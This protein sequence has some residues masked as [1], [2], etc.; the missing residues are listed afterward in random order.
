MSIP[1][2][3]MLPPTERYVGAFPSAEAVAFINGMKQ[4]M[5]FFDDGE[6]LVYNAPPRYVE[7]EPSEVVHPITYPPSGFVLKDGQW[8]YEGERSMK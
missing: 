4:K 5:K 1:G 2:C 8:V 3:T 7:V 6:R